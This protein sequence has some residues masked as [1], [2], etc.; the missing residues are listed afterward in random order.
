MFQTGEIIVH[1]GVI[2]DQHSQMEKS[3]PS[4]KTPMVESKTIEL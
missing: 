1:R 3:F 4:E 2:S